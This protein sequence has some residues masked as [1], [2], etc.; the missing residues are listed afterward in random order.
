MMF[1][2]DLSYQLWRVRTVLRIDM[3]DSSY[4]RTIKWPEPTYFETPSIGVNVSEYRVQALVIILL[5]YIYISS[6]ILN[7]YVPPAVGIYIVIYL[8]VIEEALYPF[9]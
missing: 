2:I 9:C 4:Q 1:A 7:F 6:F 8:W 5:L 3:L